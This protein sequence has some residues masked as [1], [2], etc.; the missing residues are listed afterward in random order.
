[1]GDWW[2]IICEVTRTSTVVTQAPTRALTFTVHELCEAHASA[3][4]IVTG[5][6]RSQF[7]CRHAHATTG[8]AL[9]LPEEEGF[10]E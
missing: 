10:Q 2:A 3:D 7:V 8:T 4:K 6:V 1:M 9:P 5:Y